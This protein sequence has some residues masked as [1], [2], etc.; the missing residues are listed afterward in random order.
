MRGWRW[1]VPWWTAHVVIDSSCLIV[2][3]SLCGCC[4]NVTL[5]GCLVFYSGGERTRLSNLEISSKSL[6]FALMKNSLIGKLHFIYLEWNKPNFQDHTMN[7]RNTKRYKFIR[8][9]KIGDT[10][11]QER[12]SSVSTRSIATNSSWIL[13]RRGSAC[14]TRSTRSCRGMK[15]NRRSI[16]KIK[17]FSLHK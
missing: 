12:L 11:N 3:L 1:C 14:R 17:I 16:K 4:P 7:N 8:R 15:G 9:G 2:M 5:N 13:W 10:N 6:F